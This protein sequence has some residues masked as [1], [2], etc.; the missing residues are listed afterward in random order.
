MKQAI[1][2]LEKQLPVWMETAVIPGLSLAIIHEG[3]M[4][5][6][7]GYGV[8][9]MNTKEVVTTETVFEAA[10]LTKPLY[11]AAI[12]QLVEDGLL[13]LDTPLLTYLPEAEQ[14]AERLFDRE[15]DAAEY[16]FGY[17][18]N[19]P[20]LHQLTLRHILSHT[21]GF[22]NWTDSGEPLRFFFTPGARFSYSGDGYNM[23][24]K[25][26]ARVTD[27]NPAVMMQERLL[28]P[29]GMAH[30]GLTSQGV[31]GLHVAAKHDE[32]G[33]IESQSEWKT[34]YAAAS[35]HTTAP[36]YGRFLLSLL[37][38]NSSNPACLQPE[39][40]AQLWQPQ[41]QVNWNVPWSDNW[42]IEKPELL[43]DVAW[44]LGWGL[45]MSDGR[46]AFWHWGDNG[47]FKAFTLGFPDVG[48]AVVMLSNS[49]N[50]DTLWQPILQRLYDGD[51]PALDW[52]ENC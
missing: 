28:G 24:Q 48:S 20:C 9:D 13:D 11:A 49:K 10:S 25:I 16:L 29:L 35:L 52:L 43:P 51:Y 4:A 12:L 7:R 23:L 42:P 8:A 33:E 14:Q 18:P 32:E 26:V 37:N 6:M 22:P 41:V 17:V 21:P 31:A 1:A 2:E 15:E 19:E 34:M 27:Q 40:I 50:G 3:E 38:P 46:L 36:D 5:W 44:G 30:S 39:T 45:Q 47:S